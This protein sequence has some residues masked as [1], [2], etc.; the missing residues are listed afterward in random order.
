MKGSDPSPISEAWRWRTSMGA[1][2]EEI[3]VVVDSYGFMTACRRRAHGGSSIYLVAGLEADGEGGP[4]REKR[5]Q[6]SLN[7][8]D[9]LKTGRPK[10][11]RDLRQPAWRGDRRNRVG[12]QQRDCGGGGEVSDAEIIRSREAEL[13]LRASELTADTE[14][15]RT[16]R[17][18]TRRLIT[19]HR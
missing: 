3:I 18:R 2:C 16:E 7:R 10:M 9:Q 14:R 15:D 12:N 8:I 4:G 11:R 17:I 5:Q 6:Q 1:C 19:D 13:K